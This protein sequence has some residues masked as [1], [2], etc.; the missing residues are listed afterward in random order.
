[1]TTM[2][3]GVEATMATSDVSWVRAGGLEMLGEYEG[4]GWT[5]PHYLVKRVDGQY[6]KVTGLFY[7]ILEAVDS[8]RTAEEVHASVAPSSQ[9]T[10]ADVESMLGE[11]LAVVG[12]VQRADGVDRS[13]PRKAE[14]ILALGL[15]GTIVPERGVRVVA[16]ALAFFF[17]W[18]VVA[19]VMTMLVVTDIWLLLTADAL[20]GLDAVI[21]APLIAIPVSTLALTLPLLHEFGHAAGCHFSGGRPGRIGFGIFIVWPAL[22]TDLTDAYRLPRAGRLRSDLGGVYFSVIGI[23]LVTTAYAISG[24]EVLVLLLIAL[25]VQALEQFMP[26]IRQDGYYLLGDVSGVPDPYAVLVPALRSSIPG[27][28]VDPKVAGLRPATRRILTAWAL[29]LVPFVALGLAITAWMLPNAIPRWMESW[30]RH[31]EA[32]RGAIDGG[33]VLMGLYSGAS[34]L[35][36]LVPVLGGAIVLS[37]VVRSVRRVSRRRKQARMSRRAQG[38]GA[39]PASTGTAIARH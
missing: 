35:M 16:R 6:A 27:S 33:D 11:H 13:P 34:V 2:R 32:V 38:E 5:D 1:M 17:H 20:A 39:V 9:V 22:F 15:R 3:D 30:A 14:P 4:G 28:P 18:P 36:L 10:V 8:P 29:M 7:R 23:L 21:A 26:F 19:A 37:R 24:F 31:S 12:L 25:H